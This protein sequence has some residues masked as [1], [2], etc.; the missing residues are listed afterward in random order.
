VLGVFG[1]GVDSP[2]CLVY[3]W[4]INYKR[5]TTGRLA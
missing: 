5:A 4:V 2:K 1:L 3:R